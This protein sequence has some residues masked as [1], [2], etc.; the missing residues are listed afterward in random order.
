MRKILYLTMIVALMLVII[1][2]S[3]GDVQAESSQITVKDH[4]NHNVSQKQVDNDLNMEENHELSEAQ[5]IAVTQQ[6]LNHLVQETDENYKVKNY[7]SLKE[8]K[9][10]FSNI[11]SEK[12][13]NKYVNYLYEEK[14]QALYIIPTE[15]PAWF[16]PSNEYEKTSLDNNTYRITQSND[17]EMYGEYTIIFDIKLNE[18]GQPYIINV[19]Y[20]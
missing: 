3:L 8:Y 4:K 9:N 18:N 20:Q 19:Q 15:T 13:V 11:A 14:G 16:A 12:V 10:S 17:M 2:Y 1:P 7:Q 6:F 5:I